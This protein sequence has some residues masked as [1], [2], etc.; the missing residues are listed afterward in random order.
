MITSKGACLLFDF[1]KDSNKSSIIEFSLS[2]N[3][4]NDES[5][6]SLGDLLKNNKYFESVNIG[7]Y[8][9]KGNNITD[10]GIEILLPYL[11][12]NT[13]LKSIEFSQN[14]GITNKS[15]PIFLKIIK[16]S[17]IYNLDIN[18]TLIID[19]SIF[20]YPLIENYLRSDEKEIRIDFSKK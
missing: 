13:S 5:M 11:I 10:K 6:H 20:A 12:G 18:G 7:G 2:E 17:N 15:I 16:D 9:N 1:M 19:E 4:I 8:S 14:K 3:H